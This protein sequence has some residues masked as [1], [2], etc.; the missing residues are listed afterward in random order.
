MAWEPVRGGR[1]GPILRIDDLCFLH[2]VK[3]RWQDKAVPH[4]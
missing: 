3:V 4:K 2:A 1:G